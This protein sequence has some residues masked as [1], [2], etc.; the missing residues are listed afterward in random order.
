[1]KVCVWERRGGGSKDEKIG[2]GQRET[3]FRAAEMWFLKVLSSFF[4]ASL[5]M[6]SRIKQHGYRK[7]IMST[8]YLPFSPPQS[9][10]HTWSNWKTGNGQQQRMT[11]QDQRHD[12]ASLSVFITSHCPGS[13]VRLLMELWIILHAWDD[14]CEQRLKH[15]GHRLCQP[16]QRHI[17]T[18]SRPQGLK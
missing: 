1:M 8:A 17:T 10:K 9:N 15:E 3:A 12:A 13:R 5:L 2:E 4:Q 11:L 7:L 6:D 16:R 18:E 14:R